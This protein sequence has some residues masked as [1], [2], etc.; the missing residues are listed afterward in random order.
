M[1]PTDLGGIVVDQANG[2]CI[3]RTFDGKFL[4]H[5]AFNCFLKCLQADCK[6]RMI[7]VIDVAAN[8]N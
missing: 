2:F 4:A 3:E 8:A 1:N 7:F 5:F 6:E